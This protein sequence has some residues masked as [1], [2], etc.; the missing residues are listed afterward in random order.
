MHQPAGPSLS[1][2]ALEPLDQPDAAQ[3]DGGIATDVLFSQDQL[4]Q[5]RT[6]HIFR[7]DTARFPFQEHFKSMFQLSQDVPLSQL[8]KMEMA[9]ERAPL[10][11]AL[12]HGFKVAGRKC[13]SKWNKVCCTERYWKRESPM[14]LH[15]QLT[16]C[17]D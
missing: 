3:P 7:Y 13:P 2:Q 10:S 14:R 12:I 8:H 15:D 11:L 6:E 5:Q 9:E 16:I 4:R 1:T 17:D